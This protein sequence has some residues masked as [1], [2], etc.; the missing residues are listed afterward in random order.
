MS[1]TIPVVELAEVLSQAKRLGW[2]EFPE[3]SEPSDEY[4]LSN[5]RETSNWANRL[6]PRLRALAGYGDA[7]HGTFQVHRDVAVIMEGDEDDVPAEAT[8]MSTSMLYEDIV[9]AFDEG[10]RAAMDGEDLPG[11]RA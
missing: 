7:G 6:A 2:S 1:D 9:D 11:V 5:F 4:P 8:V 3:T 10:A